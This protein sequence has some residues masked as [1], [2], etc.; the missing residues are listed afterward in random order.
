MK[1]F[2]VFFK[3]EQEIMIGFGKITGN[4]ALGTK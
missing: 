1:T 3:S 2:A 4:D